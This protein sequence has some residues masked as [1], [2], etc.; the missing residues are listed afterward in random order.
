VSPLKGLE[1]IVR[2]AYPELPLRAE[3]VSHRLAAALMGLAVRF[4]LRCEFYDQGRLPPTPPQAG[5]NFLSPPRKRWVRDE[6][7]NQSRLQ[8]AA[9]SRA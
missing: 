1:D 5:C 6:H 7:F 8:P 2:L 3:A 4:D 9:R